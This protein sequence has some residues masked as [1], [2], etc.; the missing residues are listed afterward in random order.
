MITKIILKTR[1]RYCK[2]CPNIKECHGKIRVVRLVKMKISKKELKKV[3]KPDFGASRKTCTFC[4]ESVV[5]SKIRQPVA[6]TFATSNNKFK[7]IARII[8]MIIT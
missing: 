5:D 1:W 4:P 7:S 3:S 8:I 2:H 6:K